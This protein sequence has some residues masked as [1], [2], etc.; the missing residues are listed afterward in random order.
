MLRRPH[1]AATSTTNVANLV[2][3]GSRP[4][5]E[6]RD[7]PKT[8]SNLVEKEKELKAGEQAGRHQKL[9]DARANGGAVAHK[10]VTREADLQEKIS[11]WRT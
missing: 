8:R 5:L 6:S 10:V 2:I 1:A 11:M 4:A 7:T 9:L 3:S